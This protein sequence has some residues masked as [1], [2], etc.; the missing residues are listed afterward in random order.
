MEN[1][2]GTLTDNKAHKES[3]EPSLQLK[4]DPFEIKV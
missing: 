3:K 4:T 2:D 1:Q